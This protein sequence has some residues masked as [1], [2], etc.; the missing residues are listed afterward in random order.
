MV[1]NVSFFV[2]ISRYSLGLA[3]DPTDTKSNPDVYFNSQKFFHEGNMSTSGGGI[4]G[5]IMRASG[6]ALDTVVT[7]ISGLP[8][9]DLDHG[10]NQMMFGDNGELYWNH[11]RYVFS[12]SS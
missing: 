2:H 4:N 11:G 10:M 1:L 8:V 12:M 9:S 5:R 3:F 7:I 6:A